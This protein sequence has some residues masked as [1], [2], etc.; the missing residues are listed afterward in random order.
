MA[1]RI[2]TDTARIIME[3]LRRNLET[4]DNWIDE[5]EF[6]DLDSFM[7]FSASV[8]ELREIVEELEGCVPC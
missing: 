7:E 5:G 6:D 4:Y 3:E 1:V 8:E 2:A